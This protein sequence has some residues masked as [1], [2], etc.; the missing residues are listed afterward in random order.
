MSHYIDN[1]A[2]PPPKTADIAKM[3]PHDAQLCRADLAS[4]MVPCDKLKPKGPGASTHKH[5]P[6]SGVDGHFKASTA[7]EPKG[8]ALFMQEL[9]LESEL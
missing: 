1:W 7:G 2:L 6:G 9:Q 5:R 8:T 4:P 3:K